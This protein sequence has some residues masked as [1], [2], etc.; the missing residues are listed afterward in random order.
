MKLLRGGQIMDYVIEYGSIDECIVRRFMR[1]IFIAMSHVHAQGICHRDLKP[2]NFMLAKKDRN[3]KS[4]VQVVD[5]GLA[6]K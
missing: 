1:Q 4:K 6:F 3:M 5:F 2:E